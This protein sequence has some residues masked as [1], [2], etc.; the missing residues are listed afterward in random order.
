MSII[1]IINLWRKIIIIII[2]IIVVVAAAAVVRD[3]KLY[4]WYH[5]RNPSLT[6]SG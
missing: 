6:Q 5:G 2:I 4:P 3:K 1:V